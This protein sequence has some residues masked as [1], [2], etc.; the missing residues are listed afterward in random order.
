MIGLAAMRPAKVEPS[1]NSMVRAPDIV[2]TAAEKALRS[3]GWPQS[4][5][6]G[7]E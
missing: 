1:S 4:R 7:R 3:D 2:R 6:F 5:P